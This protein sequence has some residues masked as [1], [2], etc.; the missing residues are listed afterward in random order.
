M[1]RERKLRQVLNVRLDE[2]MARELRRI[3]ASEERSESEVAR[4]L[5]SYGIDVARQLEA[6]RLSVPY[7]EQYEE[8]EQLMVEEINA[9]WRVGTDF[10]RVRAGD[11]SPSGFDEEERE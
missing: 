3:A 9:T 4:R 5:L 1:T 10:E 8:Y 11:L 6:E 2:Q 7:R